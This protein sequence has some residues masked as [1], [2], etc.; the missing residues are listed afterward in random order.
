VPESVMAI[1]SILIDTANTRYFARPGF[2]FSSRI[3]A[4]GKPSYNVCLMKFLKDRQDTRLF[5]NLQDIFF[6]RLSLVRI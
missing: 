5:Q 1:S 3:Y 4:D 2:G 6:V